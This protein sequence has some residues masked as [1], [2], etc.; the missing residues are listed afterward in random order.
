MSSF[1]P[2]L[3]SLS[4]I[5]DHQAKDLEDH[6]AEGIDNDDKSNA[7]GSHVNTAV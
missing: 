7:M 1:D 3:P 4:V 6:R 5:C 2:G